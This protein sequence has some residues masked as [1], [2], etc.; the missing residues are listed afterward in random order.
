MHLFYPVGLKVKMWF[1]KE[2]QI[3]HSEIKTSAK[4][5]YYL[6]ETLNVF[7]SMFYL[8]AA[9]DMMNL[10]E[11]FIFSKSLTAL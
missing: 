3:L 10:T 7:K 1:F 4:A 2:N 8:S 9:K 11:L 5:K 6:M